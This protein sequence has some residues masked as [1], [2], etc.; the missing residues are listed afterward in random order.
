[1][2]KPSIPLQVREEAVQIIDKFNR[3][4]LAR[5]GSRYIPRF[6]GKYL[7][8]DR[9]DSGELG[10]VCRLEYVNRK[11]G[12][13]F[14]IYKYSADRYDEEAWFLPGSRLVDGSINGALK[15]GMVVYPPVRQK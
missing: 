1:M 12:W 10:H 11:R 2:N 6:R 4:E 8:L 3:K 5:T 7:Y 15:A 13:Y 14:A 9:D